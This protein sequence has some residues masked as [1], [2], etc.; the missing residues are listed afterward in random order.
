MFPLANSRELVHG[1]DRDPVDFGLAA[2]DDV[3]LECLRPYTS[4]EDADGFVASKSS[5]VGSFLG[6]LCDNLRTRRGDSSPEPS[7]GDELMGTNLLNLGGRGGKR[8]AQLSI[9]EDERTGGGGSTEKTPRAVY[10]VSIA[11]N[12]QSEPLPTSVFIVDN[13]AIDFVTTSPRSCCR[14]RSSSAFKN[15]A[16]MS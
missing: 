16:N 7:G 4:D 8:G 10:K 9:P 5:A 12:H 14:L 1:G 11:I 13:E 3:A 2:R 6:I 15:W